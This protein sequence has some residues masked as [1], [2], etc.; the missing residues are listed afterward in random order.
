[1]DLGKHRWNI[2]ALLT[3]HKS[4]ASYPETQNL[5]HKIF[6]AVLFFEKLNMN[7][8]QDS[9]PQLLIERGAFFVLDLDYSI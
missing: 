4:D 8:A 2:S 6:C 5:K 9:L 1:M 7:S 3:Q